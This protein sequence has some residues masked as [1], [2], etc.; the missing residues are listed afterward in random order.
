MQCGA[1]DAVIERVLYTLSE[2]ANQPSIIFPCFSVQQALIILV[3]A[4]H[5]FLAPPNKLFPRRLA[6]LAQSTPDSQSYVNSGG[7]F[8]Y[9]FVCTLAFVH[10]RAFDFPQWHIR[11]GN[12]YVAL[13][14]A[15]EVVYYTHTHTHGSMRRRSGWTHFPGNLDQS[16]A[17]TGHSIP[18]FPSSSSSRYVINGLNKDPAR[19]A[20]IQPQYN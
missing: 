1:V 19:R 18:F 17:G 14:P 2:M 16:I 7:S 13:D 3:R 6:S 15:F 8:I 9:G 4:C 10:L 20:C 11:Y 12:I 5:N